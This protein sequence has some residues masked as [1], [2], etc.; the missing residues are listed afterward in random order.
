MIA[1]V[2]GG[3]G[4]GKSTWAEG[5]VR[6]L[7]RPLIY[8]ATMRVVDEECAA[9]VSRHRAQRAGLGF[10]T[11]ECPVDVGAAAVRPGGTALLECLP[12]LV[13]NEMFGGEAARVLPGVLRLAEAY[14]NLVVVTND[15]FSDGLSYEAD[16]LSYMRFLAALNRE[17]ARR[18]DL[19]A[20]V[21]FSI[22]VLL[23]GAY[24]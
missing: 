22:P 15:V 21:V 1:L 7:G 10:A 16:T 6:A 19:V 5:F 8:I 17:M 14:N 2:T 3:S 18:A 20:E 9:R 24:P 23:K 12:T 11:L 4:C 13:A